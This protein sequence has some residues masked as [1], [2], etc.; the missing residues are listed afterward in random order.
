MS[1]ILDA[2]RKSDQ[3]RRR[4]AAPTLIAA[5]ATP[6]A[7]NQPGFLAYG[8]LA[9]VLVG[10]GVVIGWLRPWQ[11]QQAVPGRPEPVAA[12]P[13]ESTARQPVP[14]TSEMVPQPKPEPTLQDAAQPAQAAPAPSEMA[15][16]P[17]PRSKPGLPAR[18]KP[19]TDGLPREADAAAPGRNAPPAPERPVDTA[20]ADAAEA[21]AVISMADLPLSVRQE[22]PVMAISVHAYSGNP[23]AR[24]V[25]IGNRILRE[26]DYVVPG[27]KL[28]EITPD[29]MIFGYKGYRF[30]RGVK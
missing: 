20:P 24:L 7:R 22:L 28:E 1:Y 21:Q 17:K 6:V 18:A 16:Q 8:L 29:G 4:G 5:L 13:L 25:G 23:G 11:S 2:L 19:R 30:R 12:K 27:L 9:A 10:A 26:G 14:A 3:Q 15:S